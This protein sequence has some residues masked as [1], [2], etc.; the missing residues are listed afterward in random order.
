M[1]MSKE[2][3]K[4]I[5]PLIMKRR[6]AVPKRLTVNHYIFA[7]KMGQQLQATYP[8]GDSGVLLTSAVEQKLHGNTIDHDVFLGD[9][10]ASSAFYFLLVDKN[11]QPEDVILVWGT[12]PAHDH[13]QL[14]E[15]LGFFM[16]KPTDEIRSG[17]IGKIRIPQIGKWVTVAIIDSVSSEVPPQI[18]EQN[19]AKTLVGN[20][21]LPV[22][23]DGKPIYV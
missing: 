17:H 18:A 9:R 1:A 21:I 11:Q 23:S 13:E 10:Q 7:R 16:Q 14:H 4:A 3:R 22:G 2:I 15:D 20:F 6:L 19:I 5:E 8:S 12:T